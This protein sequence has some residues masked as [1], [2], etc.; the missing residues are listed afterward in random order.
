MEFKDIRK[1]YVKYIIELFKKFENRENYI[2]HN[3]I[4]I[5]KQIEKNILEITYYECNNYGELIKDIKSENKYTERFIDLYKSNMRIFLSNCDIDG[6]I[7]NKNL[8]ECIYNNTFTPKQ[9]CEN[10]LKCPQILF[11]ER[12]QKYYDYIEQQEDVAYDKDK[13]N[14]NSEYKCKKCKQNK[15]TTNQAQLRSADEPMSTLITCLNCNHRWQIN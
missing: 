7:D 11:K 13:L 1:Q 12:N 5:S 4:V 14:I 15:C 10:I 2:L 8:I 9:I 6:Y 3:K